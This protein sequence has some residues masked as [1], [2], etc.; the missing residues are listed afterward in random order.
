[1]IACEVDVLA[2]HH[3]H[4]GVKRQ[5]AEF[6]LAGPGRMSGRHAAVEVEDG[7]GVAGAKEVEVEVDTADL[8]RARDWLGSPRAA[9]RREQRKPGASQSF[10]PDACRSARR[11]P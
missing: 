1:M 5:A 7:R 4:V 3:T 2:C 6:A 11:E 8:G 10:S 9:S